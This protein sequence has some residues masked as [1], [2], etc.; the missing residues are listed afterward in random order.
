MLVGMV[1]FQVETLH[2]WHA[3]NSDGGLCF[4][5]AVPVDLD[6]ETQAELSGSY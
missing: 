1:A 5:P 6:M 2:C 3:A 4:T